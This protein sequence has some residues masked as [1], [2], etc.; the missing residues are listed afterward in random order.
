M[1]LVL[2]LY[3]HCNVRP[4]ELDELMIRPEFVSETQIAKLDEELGS[5]QY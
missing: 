3:C 1:I 4:I 2:P 5:G